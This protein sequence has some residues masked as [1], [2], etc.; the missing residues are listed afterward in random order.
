MATALHWGARLL[1]KACHGAGSHGRHAAC[2]SKKHQ[3]PP[4]EREREREIR[5]EIRRDK[6]RD[7]EKDR[8]KKREKKEREKERERERERERNRERE[9]EREMIE[10]HK[11]LGHSDLEGFTRTKVQ[12]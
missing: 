12:N 2:T 6:E 11:S 7:S 5:R 4:V 10:S 9:R 8:E 3:W 1:K